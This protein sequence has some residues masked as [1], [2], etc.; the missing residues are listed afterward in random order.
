MSEANERI[1]DE[2]YRHGW[3][4]YPSFLD[5]AQ[6]RALAAESRVAWEEGQ[7]RQAGVGTGAELRVDR[8]VRRDH[9][10]WLDDAGLTPTQR[11]YYQRLESLRTA[12]NRELQLGLFSFEGHLTVYPAGGFY[13]RHLDQF[14]GARHRVVSCILYLNPD[15]QPED[16]GELRLY[17]DEQGAQVDVLPRGGTLVAFLSE[18]FPHEVLP[19]RRERLSLTGWFRTRE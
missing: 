16:G 11:L 9:V 8:S 14:R 5:P 18:R 6:T 7:F 17:L 15:W 10:S 3:C 4:E 13:R 1:V 2:L 19:A 12:V